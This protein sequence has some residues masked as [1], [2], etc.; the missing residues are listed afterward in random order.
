MPPAPCRSTTC[1][2]RT[3]PARG[4]LCCIA[5]S[6][7]VQP[8]IPLSFC[9]TLQ[10]HA[11][12]TKDHHAPLAA[13]P[14]NGGMTG[15]GP[16]RLLLLPRCGLAM[17]RASG[18]Q[19]APNELQGLV[20]GLQDPQ[21]KGVTQ[22]EP[23]ITQATI[24]Q[25]H[26]SL[27]TNHRNLEHCRVSCTRPWW[28]VFLQGLRLSPASFRKIITSTL[29]PSLAWSHSFLESCILP[30]GDRHLCRHG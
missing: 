11:K 23:T 7:Q 17:L 6:N 26:R 24:N 22:G 12:T 15:P 28:G 14:K 21:L 4:C 1:E 3:F 27:A 30:P 18:V 8:T 5:L 16:G 19:E 2:G 29:S 25:H 20:L 10:P 9:F 13:R